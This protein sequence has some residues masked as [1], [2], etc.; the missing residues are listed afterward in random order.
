M[1]VGL[2]R[3]G[4]GGRQAGRDDLAFESTTFSLST[5]VPRPPERRSEGRIAPDLPLAKLLA[6]GWQDLC[7]I[8]NISAGGLMAETTGT[9]P[10]VDS[11]IC[12]EFNSHHR[13]SGRLVWTR[14]PLIGIKFDRDVDLRKLLSK[15][16]KRGGQVQRPPRLEIQCGATVRIGK[17]YHNAE[18]RDISLG[19]VKVELNDWQCVG[20]PTVITVESLRPIR[21]IIRWYKNGHAGI[22]FDKPLKF[23]ELAEWLGKRVAVASLKTGAWDSELP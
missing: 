16:S 20:K 18:V 9:M 1:L 4:L 3:R 6:D 15:P 19:G 21:G 22:V 10:P 23:E 5:Q 14:P 13:M 2:I 8:W 17:L 7:R 11:D 12:I